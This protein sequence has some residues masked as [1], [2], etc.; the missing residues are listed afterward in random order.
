MKILISFTAFWLL[1][2]GSLKAQKSI[3]ARVI[4]ETTRAPL[5]GVT[6]TIKNGAS[7]VTD[8][9]GYF[10]IAYSGASPVL[11]LSSVGYFPF[12]ARINASQH[13]FMLKPHAI[14]MEEVTVNNGYQQLPRER[15]TGSFDKIDNTLLNR[16]VSPN[17]LDR[18]EG[19]ASSLYFSK[20]LG[21]SDLFIR[22]LSTLQG[23]TTPLIVLNNF[24]YDG[25]INTINPDDVESITVL[26]DA[27]AA[28]IWGARAGNGVIVI[29][30]KK[31][32]YSEP[33]SV[34]LNSSVTVQN[35]PDIYKAR[36]F[37]AS[38]D[39][40]SV[41]KYLFS[42]GQYDGDLS[43]IRHPVISPVVEILSRERDGTISQA[44]GDAQ[45]NALSKN[46]V[47]SDYEKY[48]YRKAVTQQYTLGLSGGSDKI[49]YLMNA[50]LDKNNLSLTGNDTRR[51]TFYTALNIKPVSRLEISST[52]TYTDYK[53]DFNGLQ[54]I[55]PGGNKAGLYPY[56]RL[57]DDE[58]NPV[59]VAK[60]YRY[61]YID[62]AGQG[63]LEN[64]HYKPLD[65]LKNQQHATI[66]QEVLLN[67]GIAYNVSQQLSLE[68]RGQYQKNYSENRNFYGPSSYFARNLVNRYT[69][70]T[71]GNLTQNITA[72]GILD[73]TYS[74]VTAYNMRAQMN[75]HATY[76]K[77][78]TLYIIAGAETREN[79]L[80]SQT[81]REYGYNDD[82][83][84]YMP[85][86]YIT[87][88][89]LYGTLG[90]GNIPQNSGFSGILNRYVS[91]FGNA[92]YSYKNKYTLS[93]SV[94][95][96]ASNLFGVN[97]NQKWN[98]FWSAGTGWK[99]SG[100]SFYHASWL[101]FL[102]ARV[103]YGYSGNINNGLSALAIIQYNTGAEVTNLPYA[104]ATQPSNPNLRWERTG[105]LNWG[106]DFATAKNII[107]GSVEYYVKKS[108]DLL[109]PV[110]VDATTGARGSLITKNAADLNTKGVDI[111]LSSSLM[112]GKIKWE[113]Q[114]LFSSVKN[115][116]TKYLYQYATKNAYINTG[117][118]IT[119]FEGGDPYALVCYRWGGLDPENGD[120]LG[121]IDGKVSKDYVKLTTPATFNDL[122]IKG[123]TRPPY[124]GSFRNS[125]YYKGFGI[126]ANIVFKWGY[127]F[128]RDALQYDELFN[129][130]IMNSEYA[131]RWQ[132]P[133]DEKT[134]NV[135]SLTY[136]SDSYR[137]QFYANSEA[138]VEKG[139]H[140]RLQDIRASYDFTI[141]SHGRQIVR[142]V[143]LYLYLN[144]VG[145]IWRANKLG[146]DPDYGTALPAA[147][148][149]S[150]G[151]KVIF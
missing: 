114:I 54:N 116:V 81:G 96:D 99:I 60:D 28:S 35:E 108:S 43:G 17:I 45:I 11:Q 39:Y 79:K 82:I 27:A 83:L 62:T 129:N 68:V 5:A 50:G 69:N 67:L 131:Q 136:P 139:D 40:I 150:I 65:E 132:K 32:K 92:A 59:A 49:N 12:E 140:I 119:P 135:P 84:T 33:F 78:H 61:G 34:S 21:K 3:S 111:K 13:L 24:P 53:S 93:A 19:T 144:N 94:R 102:K 123:T 128:R 25:D 112:L 64:W 143:Q 74:S 10:K 95:K 104:V 89:K 73:E 87:R 134:T 147:L 88:F 44:D 30:T 133:G 16:S 100:E 98:P 77:A 141:N 106:L 97:T 110:P 105:T 101:P 70:I 41:E 151:V 36:N 86:D 117:Y 23:N 37:M 6:V 31:G 71:D 48:V 15:S 85:V 1:F 145:I 56:A 113:G 8:S 2:A 47:R 55:S 122:V 103:T 124:F 120:P 57:A 51:N 107:T 137:D 90:S 142:D 66:S 130:W 146:I 75:Y 125:F 20:V 126:S 149:T 18:L 127:Y 63:T 14:S 4:N 91:F 52:I 38:P 109:E 115:K 46:D 58:G 121:Y 138:T 148:S 7:A 80:T 26:K 42:Q 118:L 72:G 29:T 9:S 22:G 76:G